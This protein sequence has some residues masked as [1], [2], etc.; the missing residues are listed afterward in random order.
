MVAAEV[1]ETIEEIKQRIISG[2]WIQGAFSTPAGCCV[3]GAGLKV[4]RS[5]RP[6]DYVVLGEWLVSDAY[7]EIIRRAN[8]HHNADFGSIS[9]WNDQSGRKFE[10]IIF[11][12]SNENWE[13][14]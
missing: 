10:D 12:L 2:G 5:R 9:V 8:A 3:S 4:T 14:R 1:L 13:N 11:V 6:S 7:V